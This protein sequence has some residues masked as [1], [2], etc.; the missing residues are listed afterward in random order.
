MQTVRLPPTSDQVEVARR[1]CSSRSENWRGRR[2]PSIS[3]VERIAVAAD[4]IAIG[5]PTASVS[6]AGAIS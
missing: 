3:T 6:E 4:E 5:V 2:G 1:G